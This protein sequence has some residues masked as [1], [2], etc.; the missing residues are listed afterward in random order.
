MAKTIGKTVTGLRKVINKPFLLITIGTI[1][2]L[3]DII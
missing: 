2:I 3:L 1:A